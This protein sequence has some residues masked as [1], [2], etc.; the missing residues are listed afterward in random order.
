MIAK[1]LS[2]HYTREGHSTDQST[3]MPKQIINSF[4]PTRFKL[5]ASIGFTLTYIVAAFIRIISAS[6]LLN[7]INAQSSGRIVLIAVNWIILAALLYITSFFIF[8]KKILS[9]YSLKQKETLA[10]VTILGLLL[11]NLFFEMPRFLS[12]IFTTLASDGHVGSF[13][14]I[15]IAELLLSYILFSLLLYFMEKFKK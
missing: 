11:S 10:L 15:V 12:L 8:S 7:L 2:R 13:A 4:R 1:T 5:I 3:N 9:V 14:L 6:L